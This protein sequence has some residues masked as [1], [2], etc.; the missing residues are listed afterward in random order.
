MDGHGNA[1]SRSRDVE[2][3]AVRLRTD[4]NRNHAKCPDSFT[5]RTPEQNDTTAASRIAAAAYRD[6]AD[7][8]PAERPLAR[9]RGTSAVALFEVLRSHE[10]SVSRFALMLG[11]NEKIVRGWLDGSRSVPLGCV[12]AMPVEMGTE[13]MER[14]L[15]ERAGGAR[16]PMRA[17]AALREATARVDASSVSEA[18]RP[19]LRRAI[20]SAADKLAGVLASLELEK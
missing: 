16:S 7:S 20:T 10:V 2:T 1:G 4:N 12:L 5:D 6:W 13:L 11:I 17:I 9:A 15:D 18:S 14:L 19:E 8:A 3:R